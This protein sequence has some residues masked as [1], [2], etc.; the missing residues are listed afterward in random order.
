MIPIR[1]SALRDAQVVMV[2]EGSSRVVGAWADDQDW[3]I[4]YFILGVGSADYIVPTPLFTVDDRYRLMLHR[5]ARGLKAGSVA[6][7]HSWDIPFATDRAAEKE[8]LSRYGVPAYWSGERIWSDWMTP[9]GMMREWRD[10]EPESRQQSADVLSMRLFQTQRLNGDE[11][12]CPDGIFGSV[13]DL[14]I[15]GDT[16]AIRYLIVRAAPESDDTRADRSSDESDDESPALIS[17]F[18]GEVDLEHDQVR[19]A[20]TRGTI[21]RSPVYTP[22]ALTP[23]DEALLARYYGFARNW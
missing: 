9:T 3:V 23:K 10:G 11:I 7:D 5:D 6:A 2:D 12:G 21:E 16:W 13:E 1:L 17:P 19:L 22:E 18:W 8:L 20:F 15:D 14:L 4:R